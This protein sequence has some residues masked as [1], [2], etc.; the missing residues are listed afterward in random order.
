MGS[1]TPRATEELVLSPEEI[2]QL[3]A[4][5]Q[6]QGRSGGWS[7]TDPLPS[8]VDFSGFRA[9]KVS[10]GPDWAAIA[11]NDKGEILT[12]TG[13]KTPESLAKVLRM[14]KRAHAALC[15]VTQA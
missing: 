12:S 10:N 8:E 13:P 5:R 4:L 14:T 7:A 9:V 1:E 6:S 2:Q 15:S 11:Y 3:D